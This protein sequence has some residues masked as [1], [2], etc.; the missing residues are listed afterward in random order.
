MARKN[1]KA[2]R[3][4]EISLSEFCFM[5]QGGQY[6]IR[7]IREKTVKQAP[8]SAHKPLYSPKS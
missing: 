3:K 7:Q 1:N 4:L 5:I 2:T 8:K 6:M